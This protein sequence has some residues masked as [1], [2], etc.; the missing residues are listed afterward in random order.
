MAGRFIAAGM[1]AT[2]RNYGV[3]NKVPKL[4]YAGNDVIHSFI[5]QQ[6]KPV[7]WEEA[8]GNVQHGET[9]FHFSFKAVLFPNSADQVAPWTGENFLPIGPRCNCV[10]LQRCCLQ[11]LQEYWA[12]SF[13]LHCTPQSQP[14]DCKHAAHHGAHKGSLQRYNARQADLSS[15]MCLWRLARELKGKTWEQR[16]PSFSGNQTSM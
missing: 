15:G 7:F 13:S 3:Q 14:S 10:T 2:T 5:Q 9:K 11:R 16:Q 4:R 1:A 12:K 8:V 6:R